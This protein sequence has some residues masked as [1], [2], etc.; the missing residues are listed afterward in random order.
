[1]HGFLGGR[2]VGYF[3][4]EK[5]QSPVSKF[6]Y[7][8]LYSQSIFNGTNGECAGSHNKPCIIQTQK[9]DIPDKICIRYGLLSDLLKYLP[10]PL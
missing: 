8:A 10:G 4:P 1:M 5:P 6:P 3:M 2:A 9:H 7:V